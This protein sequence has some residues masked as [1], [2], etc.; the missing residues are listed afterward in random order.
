MR[1]R[2]R[3]LLPW[4]GLAVLPTILALVLSFRLSLQ[5]SS[6]TNQEQ[7][8]ILETVNNNANQIMS[9]EEINLRMDN[10]RQVVERQV[11][12][13]RV[14][15]IVVGIILSLAIIGAAFYVNDRLVSPFEWMAGTSTRVFRILQS[16]NKELPKPPRTDEMNMMSHT[17]GIMETQ[18]KAIFSDLEKQV[19]LRT[20]QL[21]QRT[22]QLQ[23]AA[24]IVRQAADVLDV[25]Q[26]L[27]DAVR[28]ISERFGYYH[29][30]VYLL[31]ARGEMAI[32]AA[33]DNSDG[34]RKLM[35]SG[36]RVQAGKEGGH[37]GWVIEHNEAFISNNVLFDERFQPNPDL[38][39][40]HSVAA[41]PLRARGQMIGVLDIHSTALIVF[42]ES[43]M[44]VLQVLADQLSLA[45][46]NTRLLERSRQALEA[47]RRAYGEISRQEWNEMIR[48]RPDWGLR[49]DGTGVSRVEGGLKPWMVEA[50]LKSSPVIH[51]D[52][53]QNIISLPIHIRGIVIGVL[54][55]RKSG[56]GETWSTDEI[57]LL[58]QLVEQFSQALEN[59]RLY[60]E[61][62]LRAEREAIL[63]DIT[64]KV[65]ASTNVNIILQ[66]AVREL[67]EALHVQK[68]TV[69]LRLRDGG[70]L[71]V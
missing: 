6:V 18:F 2:Y 33:S 29:T 70:R 1:I 43:E 25:R 69:Q 51:S 19:D 32:I 17:L 46:D 42:G 31:D 5:V 9:S 59:A 24:Q 16:I 11:R 3:F 35:D 61:T 66:T 34:G 58:E 63:S 71:D 57:H 54:D 27:A 7:Q 14:I 41:M 21:M 20:G 15:T 36:H 22:S 65:R 44:A 13:N 38:P 49:A 62:Q 68:S 39:A 48:A 40:T 37:I 56:E 8:R 45:I 4:I 47:E 60:Q 55:F 12:T 52:G 64:S 50:A 23:A 30:S 26:L 28:L 10:L 67:A 53:N